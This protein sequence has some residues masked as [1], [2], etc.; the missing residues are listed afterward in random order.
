MEAKKHSGQIGRH[1][2]MHN[3]G[4][5]MVIMGNERKWREDCML[6]IGMRFRKG[7]L[8]R[9]KRVAMEDI[10]HDLIGQRALV[11]EN[12]H[13]RGGVPREGGGRGTSVWQYPMALA[14]QC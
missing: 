13:K 14:V 5:W 9:V 6:P 2:Y 8:L 1:K 3:V 4:N 12:G 7:R 11:P 10:G